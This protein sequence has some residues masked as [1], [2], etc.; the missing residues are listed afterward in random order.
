M[1]FVYRLGVLDKFDYGKHKDIS[2]YFRLR[3][4]IGL[5]VNDKNIKSSLH[6][7][8]AYKCDSLSPHINSPVKSLAVSSF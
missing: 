7:K 3:P 6:V 4:T 1:W 2:L 5:W 8:C